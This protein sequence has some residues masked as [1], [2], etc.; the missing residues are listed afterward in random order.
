MIRKSRQ[1]WIQVLAVGFIFAASTYILTGEIKGALTNALTI[2]AASQLLHRAGSGHG[3]PIRDSAG[4]STL[5]FDAIYFINMDTRYD[6][7]D[8]ASLQAY[9]SGIDITL[10]PG[11]SPDMMHDVGMPPT[12]EPGLLGGGQKGCWRAH[13]NVRDQINQH[14]LFA[15]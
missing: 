8:A 9:L 1:F 15:C 13:A 11:V 6:R 14:L 12:H 3:D 7:L 10:S 5:G 2:S 4:N